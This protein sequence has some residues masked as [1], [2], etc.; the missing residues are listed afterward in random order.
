MN[1][2]RALGT[3]DAYLLGNRATI[4]SYVSL[5][6]GFAS[7]VL[8]HHADPGLADMLLKIQAGVLLANGVMTATATELGSGTSKHYKRAVEHIKRIWNLR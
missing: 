8:A 4:M 5:Y 7:S 3:I 1:V 2:G 6:A